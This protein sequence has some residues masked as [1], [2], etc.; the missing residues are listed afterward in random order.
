MKLPFLQNNTGQSNKF[1]SININS[2]DVKCLAVYY[3]SGS[4]K[5]IGS[6][7]E[8]LEKGS[9]R[10]SIIVDKEDVARAVKSA[11]T[12]AVEN[13]EDKVNGVI[14]GV[15][16]DLC[17]GLVTTLRYKKPATGVFE[18]KEIDTVYEKV[19]ESAYI[20][21]Q[22]EHLETTGNPDVDLETIT[23]SNVFIKIDGRTVDHLEDQTGNTAEVAVF[24]AFSPSF[25]IKT[26]QEIAKK[27][28]LNIIAVGSEMYAVSQWLKQYSR[29]TSDF[30]LL[31]I[32]GESTNSAVVFGGG[33]VSTK[34][35]NIGYMHFA[36][37]IGEKM[38]I[39]LLEA[40]KMLKGYIAGKLTESETTLVQNCVMDTVNIWLSGVE[41]MFS[42]FSNVKTFPSLIY[43]T[44]F[45]AEIKDVI[46]TLKSE[47]WTKSI[48]FK[49]FPEILKVNFSDFAKISDSTGSVGGPDWLST[50]SMS[51]IYEEIFGE[52]GL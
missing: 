3:D 42:E 22:N 44:G 28:G 46:S 25:H 47:P 1:L 50:I 10:N 14:F 18:K 30:V 39:T 31:S 9:V 26:L 24:N 52:A 21:A 45:G 48:P 38:G 27:T 11:Y 35:L 51:I 13:L 16:G 12:S 15:S 17:L 41:L 37:G 23:T 43:L 33:I 32:D 8:I 49:E 34:S 29:G 19:N 7:R 36:E 5:I 2:N 20:Q 6:G 40:E 4:Y